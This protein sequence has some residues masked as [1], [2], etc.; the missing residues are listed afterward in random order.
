MKSVYINN[1]GPRNVL[2]YGELP[3]NT[4]KSTEVKVKIHSCSLNRLDIFTR[5]GIK[6]INLNLTKPHILGGDFAGEIIEVGQKVTDKK[7]GDR[8]VIN[9]GLICLKCENCIQG[10]TELCSNSGRIGLTTNGGYAEFGIVPSIN[11]YHIPKS[12]SFSEASTLPTVFLTAWTMLTRKSQLKDTET[13]LIVSGSSGVGAAAIQIAKNVIGAKV[14]TTTSTKEKALKAKALGADYVILNE[15]NLNQKI[16]EITNNQGVNV[17]IDHLGQKTWENAF[18]FLAKGG[19]FCICGVTSGH[20]GEIHL[21]QIF[22]NNQSIMGTFMGRH[23]DL[24]KIIQ[25]SANKQIGNIIDSEF[26]LQ[27]IKD[28]HKLMENR[29]FFGKIVI[30]I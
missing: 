11:T 25:L 14:I 3:E 23:K 8:V 27:R 16:N 22:A 4:P 29:N 2:T 20:K 19:R 17:I 26:P 1:H 7:I 21:G 12:I 13:V 18:K 10:F 28:A 24:E 15:E 6:G 5:M 30:S 9:P